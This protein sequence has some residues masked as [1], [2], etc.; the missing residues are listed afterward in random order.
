[1]TGNEATVDRVIVYPRRYLDSIALLALSAKL[2]D[3]D[4]IADARVI[5]GTSDACEPLRAA[6][7]DV[8]AVVGAADL[9][10][11]LRGRAAA[12]D[13]AVDRVDE[14]HAVAAGGSMSGSAGGSGGPAAPPVRS[15]DQ[16][17]RRGGHADV[18]VVSVPGR[19]AAPVAHDALRRGMHAMIFSDNVSL[20]DEIELKA[21]AAHNG[22]LCMGPDCGTAVLGG[23]PLG[24]VNAVRPGPIAIVGA[25]GTGIQEVMSRI[26][27]LGGGVTHAIGCGGRDL[28]EAVGGATM[29]AALRM[30]ADDAD[31]RCVALISKP[32]A[33]Q[34]VMSVAAA[35]E[36]LLTRGIPV[37]TS[38]LDLTSSGIMGLVS[39]R[40]PARMETAGTL[41]Q[42]ADRAVELTAGAVTSEPASPARIESKAGGTRIIGAFCGGTLAS[43]TRALLHTAGVSSDAITVTDFG[44]DEYT[45]GRP[46]PM[47]D[48]SLRDTA[49]IA[50]LDDPTVAVVVFDVVLG[51]GAAADPIE[52]LL[53][54]LAGRMVRHCVASVCGTDADPQD[55]SRVVARLV[56]A[57]I[58]VADSNADAARA[59]AAALL[60]QGA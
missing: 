4:G 3:V 17:A 33:P 40:G 34:V 49:I 22:V 2:L 32:P 39:T 38:F 58:T 29:I 52:A 28:S 30:L 19:F 24:F 36:P 5:L 23:V 44:D 55:R 11:A 43:E 53:P 41:A 10:I 26:H 20:A 57:G 21:V 18:A 37:I 8:P 7:F 16:F 47:I 46:H 60:G 31:V 59:A 15:I 14:L 6:G 54:R 27:R 56:G 51:F 13:T 12:V 42:V 35:C 25:S 9:V 45:V 48:P 50:A 1:M